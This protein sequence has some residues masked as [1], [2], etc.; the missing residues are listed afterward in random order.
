MDV[1]DIISASMPF[2]Q[3][4]FEAMRKGEPVENN[5]RALQTELDKLSNKPK[6]KL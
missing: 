1:R 2:W 4:D 6:R 3:K 5:G